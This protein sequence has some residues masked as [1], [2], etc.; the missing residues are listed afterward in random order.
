M[1]D[2]AGRL[3]AL[4]RYQILDTNP[5]E[6]F[7]R[8]TKVVQ[9][10]LD[11]PIALISLVDEDRQWFKSVHGLDV[12]ETARDISFCTHTVAD[13][14]PLMVEDAS[15][16]ARFCNNPLVRGDPNIRS[17]IGVPLVS[18]DGYAIGTLC[19]IDT[20]PRQHN[21]ENIALIT[22]LSELVIHEME[23]RQQAETDA[24]TGA[25]NR[26][27]FGS[28]VQKCVSLFERQKIE[29]SLLVFDLDH[30]KQVNDNFGHAAG[31]EVLRTIASEV[32]MSLRPTDVFARIGGEEF[33]ILMTGTT[34]N[35]P[36]AAAE[37]F[38]KTIANCKFEG[39]PDLEVT[40]SFGIAKISKDIGQY[41]DWLKKADRGL[42]IAKDC[43][44]NLI[45]DT[46]GP[47]G[48]Q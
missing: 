22:S 48:S 15:T 14:S 45:F 10:S 47:C 27:A 26:S 39:L 7:D 43:G 8:I 3:S 5:E 17:Y 29:S 30:F 6:R 18:P 21:V 1:D 46:N 44:R 19:A 28:E 41:S 4:K 12:T 31:D 9:L 25:L 11:V 42:Y 37:R 40:A 23:L 33:A 34:R 36:V 13:K 35:E 20:S 2:E 38:R 24:L 32:K 16:D